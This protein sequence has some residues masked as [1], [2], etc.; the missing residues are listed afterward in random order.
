MENISFPA[1]LLMFVYD[2]SMSLFA[3]ECCLTAVHSN[4]ISTSSSLQEILPHLLHAQAILTKVLLTSTD[5]L[6]G[7]QNRQKYTILICCI[8]FFLLEL[9]ALRS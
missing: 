5:R 9:F 2:A 4:P 1:T 6:K 3:S 8:A 7:I